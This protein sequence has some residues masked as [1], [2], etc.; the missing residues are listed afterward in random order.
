MKLG[1]VWSVV[2]VFAVRSELQ[3]VNSA[4][5]NS[6]PCLSVASLHADPL[7][8]LHFGAF[9]HFSPLNPPPFLPPFCVCKP[10]PLHPCT[11]NPRVPLTS[12]P[13]LWHWQCGVHPQLQPHC[14]ER[15]S[16]VHPQAHWGEGSGWKGHHRSRPVQHTNQHVLTGCH[17]GRH[18]RP[19]AGQG[20]RQVRS[21]DQT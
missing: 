1:H 13:S 11:W 10:S 21:H 6:S 15:L 17:H 14:S 20:T 4:R 12:D 9:S 3:E 16:P 18:R 19:V 2:C 8:S 5:Y 7:S